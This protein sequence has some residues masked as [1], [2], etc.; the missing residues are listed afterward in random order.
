MMTQQTHSS[1]ICKLAINHFLASIVLFRS[2]DSECIDN[3]LRGKG[4]AGVVH[5]LGLQALFVT[6]ICFLVSTYKAV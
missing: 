5:D 4:T 3:R 1:R 6:S 2:S